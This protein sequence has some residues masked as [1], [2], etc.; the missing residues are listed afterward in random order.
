MLK[1]LIKNFP[2][3]HKI[4]KKAR[5]ELNYFF[6]NNST[7]LVKNHFKFISKSGFMNQEFFEITL[8]NFKNKS[9]NI[10]ETGSSQDYGTDSSILFDSYIK[11]FGGKFITV[12]KSEEPKKHL[13]KFFSK[14]SISI[15]EDS[16]SFISSYEQKFFNTLN[17][18]YLDSFDLD[19]N[20]PE[21]SMNHCLN[22]FLC[23]DKLIKKGCYVAID[24]TPNEAAFKKYLAQS[25]QNKNKLTEENIIPGKGALVLTHPRMIDYKLEYQFY[26]VLLKKIN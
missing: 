21:D 14:N 1:K 7:K 12:D 10:F 16:V 20:N 23:I 6:L 15:V 25:V 8:N 4:Q 22:E 17:L 2:K 9:I 19:V 3:L 24:D 18:V 11:K 5:Y 13:E 26:S